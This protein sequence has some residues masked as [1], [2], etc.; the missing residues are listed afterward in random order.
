[1]S[2]SR[3]VDRLTLVCSTLV[4]AGCSLGN[5]YVV[6][7]SDPREHFCAN[8]DQCTVSEAKR[9]A[10]ELAQL[11]RGKLSAHARMESAVGAGGIVLGSAVLAL[12]IGDA[13]RDAYGAAGVLGAT[14]YG[15]STWYSNKPREEI[16]AK[17][18]LALSCATTAV[19]PVDLPPSERTKLTSTAQART[20]IFDVQDAAQNLLEKLNQGLGTS[21]ERAQAAAMIEQAQA[22]LSAASTSLDAAAKLDSAASG[23]GNVLMDGVD[24]IGSAVDDALRKTVPEGTLAIKIGSSL[25]DIA[26]KIVPGWDV[27]VAMPARSQAAAAAAAQSRGADQSI[28]AALLALSGKLI[29][30]QLEMAP[31]RGVLANFSASNIST[32]L[33]ACKL[34]GLSTLSVMP[35]EI[36]FTAGTAASASVVISNGKPPYSATTVGATASGLELKNPLPFD[37][38][39]DVSIT[40]AAAAGRHTVLVSD[41]N[42]NGV[43]LVVEVKKAASAT[44][45]TTNTTKPPDAPKPPVAPKPLTVESLISAL[46]KEHGNQALLAGKYVV[47]GFAVHDNEVMLKL[48]DDKKLEAADLA[49]VEAEIDN[50]SVLERPMKQQLDDLKL[51]LVLPK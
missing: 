8:K 28:S 19:R 17:G 11:Y 42:G 9:S 46:A 12:A 14:L 40:A 51:V 47:A 6:R 5:P 36:A 22:D 1:M 7:E 27:K 30:L 32:G 45:A 20:A 25:G 31:I 35:A 18:L 15:L 3:R 50:W 26:G 23:A 38:R 37:R 34:L 33:D 29:N 41:S 10:Y 21:E 13:H 24:A 2:S 39:L 16:Y 44:P 49:T 48:N 4:I 43:S